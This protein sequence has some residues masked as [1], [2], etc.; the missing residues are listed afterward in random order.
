MSFISRR[1]LSVFFVCIV[2]GSAL[3]ARA[4]YTRRISLGVGVVHLNN[5]SQTDFA[6]SAEFEERLDAFF[7]LGAQGNYIFSTPGIT[8]LGAPEI[9]IHPLGGEF[10]VSASPLVEFGSSTGTHWGTRLGTRIPVPFGLF[11]LV[12]TF[13]VDFI[14][15]GKDY[16][17]GIGIQF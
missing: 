10:L 16:L 11:T 17:F 2:I 7:G 9:F 15:G 14:A 6:V 8:F 4:D 12:P 3:P 13:A 1:I 5:P